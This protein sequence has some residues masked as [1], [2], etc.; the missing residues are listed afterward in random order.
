MQTALCN[1]RLQKHVFAIAMPMVLSNLTIP[2]LGLT[3]TAVA[4]HLEHAW[5]LG[6]VALGSTLIN[7]LFFLLGFLRMSTTGLTAQAY[8]AASPD[9]QLQH[10][11]HGLFSA[12]CL[13]ALLLLLQYPVIWLLLQFST[14]SM[15]VSQQA[16]LYF[17]TRIW[18]APA[19]LSNMVIIGWLLGRQNA[20]Y[21][22]LILLLT[23]LVNIVLDL[24][25]VLGFGWQV[26]GIAAASVVADYSGLL[27]GLWLVKRSLPQ[28]ALLHKS[29]PAALWHHLQHRSGISRLFRLNRD[30]FLR[31]LCLQMVFAFI[32]F[33]GAAY[34]DNIV[35][36]NA[37]L[38][39][40]LMVVSYGMDGLAYA[41]ESLT[42]QAK[43]AGNT[44]LLRDY[45]KILSCWSLLT[46]LLFSLT[47]LLM[48]PSL[49]Q[50]LT[51][52]P[53]VRQEAAVYLPWLILLPLI[54]CWAYLLD[55]VFI[56]ATE[57]RILRN[58]M[59]L[60][61]ISFIC[62]FGLMYQ[63]Q[64]HALWAAVCCFMAARAGSLGWIL[65]R[66]WPQFSSGATT[67]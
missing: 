11:A 29:L 24:L 50:L 37:I 57:G 30:I 56:G 41:A 9:G 55:G 1:T 32:A 19:T 36:A 52:L 66:R 7:V 58:T 35:A 12:V 31:S 15:E 60:A 51:S 22:M 61:L 21:P 54:A 34:G 67:D 17:S 18:S 25:F 26:Q 5:Y 33:Q 49:L 8:G 10:L 64:N 39:S 45:L 53:E 4:G 48:G 44:I 3:D 16:V 43:G 20:R 42:G 59:F 65:L 13:A 63:Y 27:L 46:G 28:H 62:S 38:L 47:Y 23:N 6:G 2:L 40:F 14:A